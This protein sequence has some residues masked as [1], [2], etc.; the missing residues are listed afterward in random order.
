MINLT[1]D[2]VFEEKHIYRGNVYRFSSGLQTLV[3]DGDSYIMYCTTPL[4]KQAV[5]TLSNVS[6]SGDEITIELYEAPTIDNTGM[7]SVSGIN[8]NRDKSDLSIV[9][10]G[11]LSTAGASISGGSLLDIQF[12]GGTSRAREQ[13]QGILSTPTL[14]KLKANTVYALKVTVSG[15]NTKILISMD[16]LL[17]S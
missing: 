4:D 13:N 7:A 3:N 12:I 1:K 9:C 10:E 14:F 2:M 16:M 5:L 6:K 11:G 15:S 17:N 8:L